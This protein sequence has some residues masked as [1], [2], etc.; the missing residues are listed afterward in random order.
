MKECAENH[1]LIYT[2]ALMLNPAGEL[3]MF[4][5]WDFN[6]PYSERLR[7]RFDQLLLLGTYGLIGIKDW[8]TVLPL[9]CDKI[10]QLNLSDG[11]D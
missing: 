3:K 2:S 11:S 8:N 7:S 10:K 4:G 6:I 1:P 9:Y 5:I